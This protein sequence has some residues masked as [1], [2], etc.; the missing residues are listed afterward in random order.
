MFTRRRPSGFSLTELS[1]ALAIIAV[2]LGSAVSV[3][4]TG[5]Y[6]AKKIQTTSKMDRINEAVSSFLA[7]YKRLPCPALPGVASTHNKFGD[8]IITSSYVEGTNEVFCQDGADTLSMNGDKITV[9]AVPVSTLG[10]PDGY[11]AD[12]WG[13]RFL[14]VVDADFVLSESQN[15]NC[16]Y[17]VMTGH[18]FALADETAD[19]DITVNGKGGVAK[20]EDGIF[21]LVSYGPNG[22]GAYP[23]YGG[24][25][26]ISAYTEDSPYYLDGSDELENAELTSSGTDNYGTTTFD[27]I[28]V[29]SP[30]VD[31][32][33]EADEEDRMYFDDFV[34]FRTKRQLIADIDISSGDEFGLA[35]KLFDA[36]C[37]F[38]DEVLS[39]PSSNRCSGAA[40]EGSCEKFAVALEERCL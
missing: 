26:R 27:G 24:T 39:N 17:S 10:L 12:G 25:E 40:D 23:G 8:E 3:L 21:V 20:T 29:Q 33:D 5:D 22:H 18:C 38:A 14:Y 7:L 19:A 13:N 32:R 28:F 35:P 4:I 9:G 31:K 36:A 11:I 6:Q 1:I 34:L 15:G 30:L 2:I 16:G 37:I